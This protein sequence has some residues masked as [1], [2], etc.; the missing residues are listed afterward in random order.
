VRRAVLDAGVFVSAV[1]TPG[2]TCAQLVPKLREG[3]FEAIVSPLL[4]KELTGVLRRDKFR[5]Y[6]D[7]E[8]VEEFVEML[9]SEATMAPDPA[10][11]A[12]LRSRDPKDDY[13]LALAFHQKAILVSGDSD[14]VELSSGAPIVTPADLLAAPA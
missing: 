4:L 7:L 8:F 10:D 13:L 14:L 5:R 6:V 11:P 3:E 12:P 2:G 9:Q 1:A